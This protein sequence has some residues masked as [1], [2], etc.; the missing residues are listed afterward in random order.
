[1][2]LTSVSATVYLGGPNVSATNGAAVSAPV[3][4]PLFGGDSVFA[5][6]ASGTATVSVLMTGA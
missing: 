3:A 4:V 5:C 2:T 1:M 6:T